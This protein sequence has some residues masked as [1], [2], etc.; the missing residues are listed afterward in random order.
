MQD[1]L[2]KQVHK[3]LR[4]ADPSSAGLNFFRFAINPDSF[5]Q[6]VENMFYISFLIRDNK[7]GI[8]MTDDGEVLVRYMEPPDEDQGGEVTKHQGVMEFD[9]DTWEVS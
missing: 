4:R 8:A 9:V 2:K 7:A 1:E 3:A 5:G 6:S